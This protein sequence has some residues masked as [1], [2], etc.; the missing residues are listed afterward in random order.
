MLNRFVVVAA[1]L[2]FSV[3]SLQ[4]EKITVEGVHLCCDQCVKAVGEALKK[5]DGVSDVKCDTKTKIV[6]FTSKDDKASGNALDELYSA[7]FSGKASKENGNV[8][9]GRVG[10]NPF[11]KSTGEVTVKGVHVCCKQCE[12]T[13]EGLFKDAKVS[14]SGSGPRKDLKITGK[15]VTKNAVWGALL[16]AGFTGKID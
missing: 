2:V 9:F 12:K 16:K 7:G 6:T 8:F 5:V 4:A 15:D 3:G 1:V 13:I 10:P 14:Y 11:E